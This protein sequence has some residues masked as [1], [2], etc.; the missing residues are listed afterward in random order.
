MLLRKTIG[1]ILA[2]IALPLA[3]QAQVI[4]SSSCQTITNVTDEPVS[5]SVLLTL[6]PGISGCAAQ[7]VT[8]AIQF[9]AGQEGVT[10]AHLTGLLATSLTSFSLGRQVLIGYDNSSSSCYATSIAVG[11]FA[12]QCP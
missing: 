8:G 1:A 2:G 12:N 11:G 4:W 7:G 10:E 5:A 3:S 6:S 9:V